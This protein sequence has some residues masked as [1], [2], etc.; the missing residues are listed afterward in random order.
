LLTSPVDGMCEQI[1]FLYCYIGYNLI[2]NIRSMAIIAILSSKGGVGKTTIATNLAS[3]LCARGQKILLVDSDQQGSSMNWGSVRNEQD[4]LGSI[5]TESMETRSK[6]NGINRN[7]GTYDHI[8]MDGAGQLDGLIVS[9][10]KV[11]DMVIIPVRPN[12]FD[13]WGITPVIEIVREHQQWMLDAFRG[14]KNLYGFLCFSQVEVG[15]DLSDQIQYVKDDL[16]FPILSTDIHHRPDYAN[17]AQVGKSV[18]ELDPY[19]EAAQEIKAL[20]T[21]ILSILAP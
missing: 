13:L 3:E 6:L 19:G 17:A 10:V 21:E 14:V 5:P 2:L 11:S 18:A 9:A 1:V 12:A 16:E 20:A 8:I 15:A 4:E 7:T